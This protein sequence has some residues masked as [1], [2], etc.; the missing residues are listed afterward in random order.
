MVVAFNVIKDFISHYASEN[1][2]PKKA[3]EYYLRT[4]E[5]QGR[6]TG[7]STK[8][9]NQRQREGWS[10][11]K[12]QVAKTKSS[13]INSA[14]STKDQ[15]I[16]QTRAQAQ[17]L[18]SDISAK[19]KAFSDSL[20]KQHADVTKSISEESKVQRQAIVDK[21][22]TDI[23]AI[24]EVPKNLPKVER[25]KLLVERSNKIQALRGQASVDRQNLNA[26]IADAKLSERT[27]TQQ[28][29]Q[30]NSESSSARRT[31]VANDLKNVVAKYLAQYNSA[32]DQIKSESKATLDK[33]FK[34]IKTKV[35]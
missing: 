19:L 34:N 13:K 5:L 23:A 15:A 4:R 14:Q 2:D 17:A 27:S 21:L 1:Y 3:H 32:K 35:R 20:T 22:S 7:N 8:G 12:A 24:P 18:R 26:S 10:Y 11:A 33:E 30:A 25:E 9:F 16:E 28:S 31:Q 29:R 6:G